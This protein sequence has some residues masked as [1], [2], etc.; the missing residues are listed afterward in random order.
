[1]SEARSFAN[2]LHETWTKLSFQVRAMVVA[3]AVFA[4]GAFGYL[5]LFDHASYGVLF[6]VSD[7]AEAGDV[8]GALDAA[9][10]PHRLSGGGTMIEVPNQDINRAR[11]L[12][13]QQE[14]PRGG[15]IDFRIYDNPSPGWT[16]ATE[17]V[18]F[19]RALQGELQRTIESL[20]AV[21]QARIHLTIP[22]QSN[23]KDE[24]VSP[25]ASVTV[26]IA[27][28]RQISESN[29]RSIQHLVSAAVERLPSDEVTVVDTKGNLLSKRGQDSVGGPALDYKRDLQRDL[30]R[31]VTQLLERVIGIGRVE[32]SIESEVDFSE[33]VTQEEFFDPEQIATRNETTEEVHEGRGESRPQGLAGAVA[34]LPGGGDKSTNE[35]NSSSSRVVKSKNYEVNRTLVETKGPKAVL[36]HLTVSVLVDGTY[37]TP[38]DGG[39]PIFSPRP[40]DE[41][42][43]LQTLVE[44]AVGFN[45]TR[46][47][48]IAVASRQFLQKPGFLGEQMVEP[49][50]RPSWMIYAAAGAA[51]V[52]VALVFVLRK[53]KQTQVA[54]AEVLAFPTSV[55]EAQKAIA[56][57]EQGQ[58]P[59]AVMREAEEPLTLDSLRSQVL[60]ST[61]RYPERAAE[62][63]KSWINRSNNS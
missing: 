16:R 20:D 12:L 30:E 36:K 52:L 44:N 2:Q 5:T 18:N 40:P 19:L 61:E 11:I 21:S 47:D 7:P 26:R 62:V 42:K 25:T 48:R 4:A 59:S 35:G 38:E 55:S 45:A 22:S 9:K 1:M 46:G 29:V 39:E 32:V 8:I 27:A 15:T 37:T 33:T 14:L 50:S 54:T 53:K 57:V 51:L 3:V 17:R 34:N 28:G 41:M 13:A 10:I 49:E 43:E 24:Q 6:Q 60:D 58:L 23:F 56:A 31:K 63:I